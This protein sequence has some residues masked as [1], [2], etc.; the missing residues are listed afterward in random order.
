MLAKLCALRFAVS[1]A[2]TAVLAA[3]VAVS[4]TEVMA[5]V[6]AEA[7]LPAAAIEDTIARMSAGDVGVWVWVWV[8]VIARSVSR[9]CGNGVE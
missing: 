9:P 6:L 5:M 4:L 3:S 7:V 1:D 2:R 8:C